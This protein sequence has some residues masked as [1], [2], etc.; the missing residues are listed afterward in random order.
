MRFMHIQSTIER[1]REA[2]YNVSG[3]FAARTTEGGKM[4]RVIAITILTLLTLTLSG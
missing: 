2:M 1:G 3:Q 4:K